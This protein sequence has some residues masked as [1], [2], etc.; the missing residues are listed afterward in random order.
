MADPI[1]L[2]TDDEAEARPLDEAFT[3]QLPIAHAV[4]DHS[5]TNQPPQSIPPARSI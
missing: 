3:E 1:P 4:P 5:L 2:F